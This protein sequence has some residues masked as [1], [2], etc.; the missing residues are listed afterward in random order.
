MKKSFITGAIA[1]VASTNLVF[2]ATV[3]NAAATYTPEIVYS[4]YET[5]LDAPP[6]LFNGKVMTTTYDGSSGTYNL[7]ATDRSTNTTVQLDADIASRYAIGD[8]EYGISAPFTSIQFD[9]KFW[10]WVDDND[11]FNYDLL[12]SDGTVAGTGVVEVDANNY[13][14]LHM[15]GTTDGIYFSNT[16]D[17]FFFDGTTATDMNVTDGFDESYPFAVRVF[18]DKVSFLAYNWDNEDVIQYT[19]EAGVE[20]E[21]G[22]VVSMYSDCLYPGRL[23]YEKQDANNAYLVN[24]DECAE[25]NELWWTNDPDTLYTSLGTEIGGGGDNAFFNGGWYFE[26]DFSDN[27]YLGLAKAVGST[28]TATH[29]V[30]YPEGFVVVGD[31][32]YFGAYNDEN[33]S[34]YNLYKMGTDNVI[35]TVV[36]D[37][38]GDFDWPV[39]VGTGDALFFS[40]LD[41]VNGEE[42]WVDDADG[43]R[44]VSDIVPGSDDS[45][46]HYLSVVGEE[47]CFGAYTADN[48]NDRSLF[49][50]GGAAALA[51]TGVDANTIGAVG[52][53]TLLVGG[54]LAVVRR[55]ARI[56]E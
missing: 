53:V 21:V 19:A 2:G 34:H 43:A 8:V 40:N 1:A 22:E 6:A 17:L 30:T 7:F 44:L 54:G 50:V 52:V 5:D 16:D 28:I 51:E 36:A 9:G 4:A 3:V 38:N 20:T 42:L 12:Y 39:G 41:D 10:T 18:Q 27:N 15:A 55:R 24:F 23:F 48:S 46:P 14:I 35:H 26:G 25:E 56:T 29:E 49:C 11:E 33:Y 31:F 37:W 13:N 47:V 32:L 45:N